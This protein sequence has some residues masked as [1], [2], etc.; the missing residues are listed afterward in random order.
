MNQMKYAAPCSLAEA[1]ELLSFHPDAVLLSGGQVVIN[2][3]SRMEIV[4]TSLIDLGRIAE[5][6]RLKE[7]ADQLWIGACVTHAQLSAST[8]VRHCLP[9][10]TEAATIIADLQVRNRATVGGTAAYG[11]SWGD[12]WPVLYAADGFIQLVSRE[13]ERD[14]PVRDWLSGRYRTNLR[15]GEIIKWVVVNK[16]RRSRFYKQP[17]RMGETVCAALAQLENG[18]L[19]LAV[20]GITALPLVVTFSPRAGTVLRRQ[21]SK[22]VEQVIASVREPS[23][24]PYK[25]HIAQRLAQ[26][27]LDEHLAE[28]AR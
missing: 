4:P 14:V 2:Q 27:L 9:A 18:E 16:S 23:A 20:S 6:A 21:E 5:L 22:R 26:R 7:S 17:I 12:Y 8:A 15:S 13:G 11:D 3:L 10:L 24:T 28:E 25:K 19:R 1:T